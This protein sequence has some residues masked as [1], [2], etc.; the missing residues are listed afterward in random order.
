MIVMLQ[1]LAI[2]IRFYFIELEADMLAV[3]YQTN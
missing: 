2:E 1:I 3:F